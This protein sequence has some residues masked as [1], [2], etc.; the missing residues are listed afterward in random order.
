MR[1]LG[2]MSAV[3]IG[4]A[5]LYNSQTHQQPVPVTATPSNYAVPNQTS[6]TTVPDGVEQQDDSDNAQPAATRS[7]ASDQ[8][9]QSDDEQSSVLSNDNYTNSDG[10]PV[11]SPAYSDTIPTGATAQCSD[12]TCSF[13][14][15]H[16]GTCSHHGGMSH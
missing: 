9:E 13:S 16:Q 6:A 1:K 15:H 7:R 2:W 12:G 5:V 14:Q 10:D 3:L 8:Q 11:H 4:C